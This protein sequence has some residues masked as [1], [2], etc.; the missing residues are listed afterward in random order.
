M[1][2]I[3][4]KRPRGTQNF[5]SGGFGSTLAA[6]HLALVLLRVWTT[7]QCGLLPRR[8]MLEEQVPWREAKRRLLAEKTISCRR[9]YFLT[10]KGSERKRGRERE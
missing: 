7:L 1:A 5:R 8:A 6:M 4:T 3:W 9:V 2:S 10:E